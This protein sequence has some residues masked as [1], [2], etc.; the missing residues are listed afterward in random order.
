MNANF[1]ILPEHERKICD[2]NEKKL[3][4]SNRSLRDLDAL[5]SENS[6]I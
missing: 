4:Y 3:E 1:G 6:D 5:K 2:K